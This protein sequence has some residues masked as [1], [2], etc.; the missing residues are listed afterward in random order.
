MEDDP[1]NTA[2]SPIDPPYQ[3]V[4]TPSD[5]IGRT[6]SRSSS[7]T[8]GR[9][10]SAS[11]RFLESGPP[12]GAWHAAGE[13]LGKAPTHGDIRR[14]SFS[15]DGW[16]A[17]I[18]RRHSVVTS[19]ESQRTFPSTT[20]NTSPTPGMRP[21][22]LD[23]HEETIAENEIFSSGSGRMGQP[24]YSADDDDDLAPEE[25]R[26]PPK[27]NLDPQLN[28]PAKAGNTS[29][30]VR[31]DPP[32]S[33]TPPS[34][35]GPDADGVYPNGYKFPPKHTRKEAISIGFKGFCKYAITPLG[36]LVVVYC[37]N[38]VAWGGMLFLLLIGGG[39][40]YMCY[41]ER[42]H[43]VKDCNDLWSPRRIWLEIDSQILNALFCVTGLGLIPWRF[44]DLFYLLQ[45]RLLRK[46][47]GLRKLGGIHNGWFRLPGSADL[48]VVPKS[49]YLAEDLDNPA[50]PIPAS[51]IPDGP[52]T[53]IRA[54]ATKLWKLDYV[55]W[56][57]VLNTFL[58][59]V[60]CAF[61][62]G[63]NRFKRPSWATGVFI[64]LACIVAG[65]GGLMT[66]K[67][68]KKVKAVEGIPPDEVEVLQDVE[69]GTELKQQD[70]KE[71]KHKPW[72]K[73]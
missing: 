4:R 47:S 1:A 3:T 38:V 58:Q 15:H 52:L 5:G 31:I 32:I 45:F 36:F 41:P 42:F 20:S 37:L 2:Y 62:W 14:G 27:R 6:M 72:S 19:P 69:K 11:L 34:N 59:C 53:G 10:R 8:S 46:Q 54:P 56:A 29:T 60:L 13:A 55:I 28:A 63:Y 12:L 22:G 70:G 49:S 25:D 39:N 64:A 71:E 57:F 23:T 18:Q 40:Q 66:F 48:P 65:L 43:G 73:Q 17:G 24:R 30:P 44:R 33:S 26:L 7:G 67:E 68:A 21:S 51:K 9:L 16:D 61:M 35:Q 50:L